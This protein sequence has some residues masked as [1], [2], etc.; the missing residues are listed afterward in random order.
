MGS[1]KS[2]RAIG[3]QDRSLDL[4]P[5]DPNELEQFMD[6]VRIDPH[7]EL[8]PDPEHPGEKFVEQ[9]VGADRALSAGLW[10]APGGVTRFDSYPVDE[11]CVVLAGTITLTASDD[12]R[13]VF[14][15]GDVFAVRRGAAVTWEQTDDTRKI[16]VVLDHGAD[17]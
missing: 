7:A 5:D 2:Y 17:G 10:A 8:E 11:I 3:S 13:Q 4:R 12:V 16:Y 9:F 1:G 6:V 15:A 14:M